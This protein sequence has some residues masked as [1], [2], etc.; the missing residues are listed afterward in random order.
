MRH[1]GKYFTASYH[2]KF[3]KEILDLKKH[4]KLVNKPDI[5]IS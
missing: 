4:D 5:L 2:N 1:W 3:T